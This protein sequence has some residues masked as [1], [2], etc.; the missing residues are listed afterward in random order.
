[1]Y[2]VCMHGHSVAP[3]SPFLKKPYGNI[4][5]KDKSSSIYA[6][7]VHCAIE[8]KLTPAAVQ[9]VRSIST[10]EKSIV[11]GGLTELILEDAPPARIA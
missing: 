5:S 11:A 8:F 6:W 1:M 4:I 7:C 3:T 10:K 9:V 2:T